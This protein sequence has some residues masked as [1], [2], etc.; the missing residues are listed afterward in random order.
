M[1][2]AVAMSLYIYNVN[3]MERADK[4]FQHFKGDCAEMFE[5]MQWCDS[6]SWATKMPPPTAKRYLHDAL[7]RYKSQATDRVLHDF[8]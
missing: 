7:D 1:I 4:L 5:L 2:D 6:P 8:I 3:V